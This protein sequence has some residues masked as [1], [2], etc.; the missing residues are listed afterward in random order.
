MCRYI[1]L[2]ELF[3]EVRVTSY[4]IEELREKTRA[5]PQG[6]PLEL[7]PW[8]QVP[9]PEIVRIPVREPIRVKK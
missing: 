2:K 7:P 4:T 8:T 1:D 6:K 5:L 9:M 3:G